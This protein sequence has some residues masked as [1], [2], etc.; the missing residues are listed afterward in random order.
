MTYYDDPKR[1][2]RGG[3]WGH[4]AGHVRVKSRLAHESALPVRVLV[5]RFTRMAS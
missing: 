4:G 5:F 1:R 3:A 2:C